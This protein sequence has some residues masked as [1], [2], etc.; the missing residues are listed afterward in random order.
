MIRRVSRSLPK[1][2]ACFG[3]R[4]YVS[5][6]DGGDAVFLAQQNS[7]Q[8]RLSMKTQ[9]MGHRGCHHTQPLTTSGAAA[10]PPRSA[11]LI[12]AT[13]HRHGSLPHPLPPPHRRRYSA[14]QAH[15]HIHLTFVRPP[16]TLTMP[17][18]VKW[19]QASQRRQR[20]KMSLSVVS[21]SHG[22]TS[23]IPRTLVLA[24]P[25]NT[26]RK[27]STFIKT[28]VYLLMRL[29]VLGKWPRRL[30]SHL[31]VTLSLRASALPLHDATSVVHALHSAQ[32]AAPRC[33]VLL[34]I[35]SR[36]TM[37]T[38]INGSSAHSRT[39]L[40]RWVHAASYALTR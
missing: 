1:R 30:A 31:A 11:A 38:R 26:P 5:T 16:Q 25:M 12:P 13:H 40:S 6:T 32:N 8:W 23:W 27:L 10:I 24:Q 37:P 22:S 15:C 3:V 34:C 19:I 35:C 2:A 7:Q 21:F 28:G 14:L 4:L 17:S 20:W 29:F 39:R 9:M 18:A 36:H 33:T